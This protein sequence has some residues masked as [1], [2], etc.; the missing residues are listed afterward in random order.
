MACTGKPGA[1]GLVPRMISVGGVQ[2][3]YL[4]YVP[5][6]LDPNQPARVVFVHH[7]YTMSGE[8]M[9]TLTQYQALADADGFVV[10]FPD[11]VGS[12][13]NAGMGVCGAG[14]FVSGNA[15]D[16]G[17]VAAMI[18]DIEASQCVDRAHVF[19][20]GF[21]MG[22]Y[23]SNRIGCK[24][25][26]LVAAVAPH[27]GGGPPAG[28]VPGVKPVM[29]IH[30]T[31]DTLITYSCGVQARDFWV[32][33]N[34]CSTAVDNVQVLGGTCEYNQNCPPGGQVVLCHMEG[35]PH[36]WAGHTGQYG[37]G[38]QYEDATALT[39]NFFKSQP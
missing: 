36:G 20:T 13:W 1:P 5:P 30:G 12:T 37:G 17:F 10:G 34:G 29:L 3:S 24:R 14:A 33:H 27:S 8:I 26:D 4:R 22:G 16:F 21:S 32:M 38:T 25:P 18:D 31:G 35:M 7:G 23:F 28:C 11:G 2:R 9:R 6:N 39:W 19:V 15:D